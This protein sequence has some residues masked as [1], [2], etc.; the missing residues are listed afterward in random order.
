LYVDNS[1]VVVVDE[2]EVVIVEDDVVAI[3]EVIEVV[4]V[5]VVELVVDAAVL[6]MPPPLPPLPL[7]PGRNIINKSISN[8]YNFFIQN[9][10]I[11]N[12]NLTCNQ[13]FDA[14]QRSEQ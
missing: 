7:Q 5:V 6:S 1:D 8:K 9:Y 14:D 4:D 13:A 2:V 3:V 12:S 10:P 11:Q